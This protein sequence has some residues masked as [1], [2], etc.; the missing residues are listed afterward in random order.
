MRDDLH[1]PNVKI[2]LPPRGDDVVVTSEIELHVEAALEHR[3]SYQIEFLVMCVEISHLRYVVA[4]A[5]HRSFRRASAALQI[6]QPTLSKLEDGLG[7]AVVRAI[8]R[9][10]A[11]ECER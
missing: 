5:E 8:Y 9:R 1:I 7:H 4:A 10:C 11:V 6:S 2:T 3:Y